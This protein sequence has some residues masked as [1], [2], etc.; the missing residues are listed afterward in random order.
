MPHSRAAVRLRGA[1]AALLAA[2]AATAVAAAPA[3]A[4]TA[5]P[6][7]TVICIEDTRTGAH[8]DYDRLVFDLSDGTLPG[9]TATLSSTGEYMPGGSGETRYLTIKGSSYLMLELAPA[10]TFDDAGNDTFTSP[11]TQAVGLPSLEGIQST[12]GYEGY[13]GFGLTLGSY[14]RYQI[15]H[16]TSPNRVIVDIYH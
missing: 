7:C 2:A 8:A 16:L 15:S 13:E 6:A 5:A 4:A 12:G 14:S 3:H 10:T 11:T 9:V 1:A